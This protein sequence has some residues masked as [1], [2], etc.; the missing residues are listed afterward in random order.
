[1]DSGRLFTLAWKVLPKLPEG[2][3][4]SAFNLAAD[5]LWRGRKGSVPQLEKNLRRVLPDADEATLREASRAAL[6]SYAQYYAEIFTTPGLAPEDLYRR[7]TLK[8]SRFGSRGAPEWQCRAR[9]GAYRQLGLRGVSG[10][11]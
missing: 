5:Q 8:L 11:A 3:I 10:V 9:A 1:M 6:R 7:T 2:M 4:A